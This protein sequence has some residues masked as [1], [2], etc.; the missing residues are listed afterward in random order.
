MPLIF[1]AV[2]SFRFIKLVKMPLFRTITRQSQVGIVKILAKEAV[3]GVAVRAAG[4]FALGIIVDPFN[5]FIVPNSQGMLITSDRAAGNI[6]SLDTSDARRTIATAIVG[7]PDVLLDLGIDIT[8]GLLRG[9]EMVV[10][11]VKA[12]IQVIGGAIQDL[13]T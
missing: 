5:N 13:V 7:T 3:K 10:G 4:L 8:Q 9:V 12:D 6:L 11:S 1:L 2:R